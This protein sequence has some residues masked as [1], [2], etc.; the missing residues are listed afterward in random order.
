MAH[1]NRQLERVDEAVDH[2]R[3]PLASPM[4]VE[5]GDYECPY[6]RRAF[7]SIERVEH[8]LTGGV[9]FV[10]RHFP[11]MGIH[12]HAFAAAEAA[13]AASIQGSFWEMH[14]L[15][16]RQ[17]NALEDEQLREYAR[18]LGLDVTQFDEERTSKPISSR[19]VRDIISGTSGG[20]EHAPTLFINGRLHDGDY[21]PRA[22]IKALAQ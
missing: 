3:G 11:R 12:P 7:L 20:A 4:I 8:E 2:I 6:S 21:D 13:E 9:R 19:I 16:F 18:Q 10:F 14:E 22:L 15:L 17:Q 1:A 5:Y